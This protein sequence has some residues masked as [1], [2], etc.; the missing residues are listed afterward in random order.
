M[1][2]LRKFFLVGFTFTLL[3]LTAKQIE[4]QAKPKSR[5]ESPHLLLGNPSGAKNSI[6]S[7]NNYLVVK[8]Q[9]ALSYNQSN[10][11][12]NWAAWE[13]NQSWLGNAKRQD[14]F[15]PDPSLPKQWKRIKPSFNK[16]S[17]Y[18][19][20]HLVPSGDRTASIEDNASTFLMSNIIPQTPDNNRNTWGNLEDWSRELVENGKNLNIIAGTWGSQGKINNL[21]NIPKYTWKII[22]ILDGPSRISGVSTQTPV[23][24]VK[25]PNNEE[26]DNDWRKFLTS[27]DELEKLTNYDFL[28]NVPKRI[29]N[30]IERNVAKL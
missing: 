22:V 6:D 26:L 4:L 17:G 16:G 3:L 7:S 30:V 2:K 23:I 13:V 29:Q 27:V 24:A 14:N 8:E 21:V 10:G 9:Y 19:R 20:G 25:I 15:R 5:E 18:D 11:T 1:V 12:A 28:S